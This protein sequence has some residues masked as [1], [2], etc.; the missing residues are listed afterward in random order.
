M[1]I[2]G[3]IV[4]EKDRIGK[5]ADISELLAKHG[6]NIESVFATAINKM[7]VIK[8]TVSD[9]PKAF[10]I[11]KEAGFNVMEESTV[12]L[13]LKN[14]PGQLARISRVLANAHININSVRVLD[15]EEEGATIAIETSDPVRTRDVL[16]EYVR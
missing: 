11:L 7:A 10:S 1:E 6:I 5:L 12:I 2:K 8:L 4:V 14:E 15:K 16:R 13:Q 9:Q 3:L